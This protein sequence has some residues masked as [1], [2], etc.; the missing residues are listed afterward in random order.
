MCFKV[1]HMKK[2]VA[3]LSMLTILGILAFGISI[4]SGAHAY[5][6]PGGGMP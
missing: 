2:I 6:L 4:L 5:L 1:K 3:M